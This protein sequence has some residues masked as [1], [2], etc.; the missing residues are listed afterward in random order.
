MNANEF[1][2]NQLKKNKLA[3]PKYTITTDANTPEEKSMASWI[4]KWHDHFDYFNNRGCGCCINIYEFD[5]PEAAI[6]E[7][8]TELVE[9]Y[10]EIHRPP[11][12][13]LPSTFS[14]F[15]Q[16]TAPKNTR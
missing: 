11:T 14:D 15:F 9:L 4:E 2:A 8:P 12:T 10:E 6:A 13:G 3:T 1:W 5:A 16:R 7:L